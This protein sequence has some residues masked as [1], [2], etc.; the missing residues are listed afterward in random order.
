MRWQEDILK[1][2]KERLKRESDELREKWEKFLTAKENI[3][4]SGMVIKSRKFTN[5]KRFLILTDTCRVIYVDPKKMEYKGKVPWSDDV[6]EFSVIV[7]DDSEWRITT[8]SRVYYFQD[9]SQ[10]ASR[11]KEAIEK[12]Q[13]EKR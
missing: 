9:V 6:K 3:V 12:L 10:N 2:E 8:P 1:E 5:K 13:S 4:E 11:W 7:K